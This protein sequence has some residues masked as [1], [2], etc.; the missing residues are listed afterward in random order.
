MTAQRTAHVIFFY[1]K[2]N[3]FQQCHNNLRPV[4]LKILGRL[5]DKSGSYETLNRIL[6]AAFSQIPTQDFKMIF[7]KDSDGILGTQWSDFKDS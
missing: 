6:E 5:G 4:C 2:R 1:C 7:E 3:I